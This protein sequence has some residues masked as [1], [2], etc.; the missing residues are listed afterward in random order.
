[1]FQTVDPIA[2]R[3]APRGIA[4][5][6][7]KPKLVC[8][9]DEPLILE[10]LQRIVRMRGLD[11]DVESFVDS[12]LA[13]EHLRN[14]NADVI[15]TDVTMPGL[16]G[17]D[18]VGLLRN[19][20]AT[21]DTPVIVLT[22]LHKASLKRQVLDLGATDLLTKPIQSDEL[23]ARLRSALRLK[24]CQDA[25]KRQNEQLEQKVAER[26]HQLQASRIEIIWRLASAAEFRDEKTGS[27]VVR[28]AHYC[29]IVAEA[30]GQ[31][32]QFVE[33]LFLSAPLHDLG[34]IGIPDAILHKPEKLTDEERRIVQTHCEIGARILSP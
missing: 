28:V 34:K 7:R 31:T 18:L 10:L 30:L 21:K 17:P 14:G 11:W 12:K 26:T 25:L 29:Q 9:D 20:E 22:G 24:Q 8:V 5:P 4:D 13:W 6:G 15:I 27:H 3:A 33:T 2:R 16:S 1:M 19:N 32:R 23:L